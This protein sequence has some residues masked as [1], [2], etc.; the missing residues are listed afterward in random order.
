MTTGPENSP[1]LKRSDPIRVPYADLG[2]IGEPAREVMVVADADVVVAGG[3]ISGVFA[4]IA[5]GRK[6][7]RT[8]LVDRFGQVGGN[9][10]P[11][12]IIG[13][14]FD[15]RTFAGLPEDTSAIP[16]PGVRGGHTGIPKEF[17]ERYAALGGAIPP[18]NVSFYPRDSNVASYVAAEMLK[19]AGVQMLLSTFVSDPIMVDGAVAGI[20]VETK[21]GR[22][23]VKAKVTIDA[24]GEADVCRR[25]GAPILYP[26]EEYNDLDS[27]SPT[28]MGIWAVV[29]G[30][31]VPR[32]RDY[33]ANTQE[34]YQVPDRE[35]PGIGTLFNGGG[36]FPYG[37]YLRE[38]DGTAGLRTQL[39]RPHHYLDAS[40][41]LHISLMEH[42][43][44]SYIFWAT[45]QLKRNVPGYEKAFVLLVSPYLTVRGGPCIEGEYTLT[46]DDCKAGRRFDDVI[47]LYG[48]SR[49]MRHTRDTFGEPRFTDMPF[50]ALVPKQ[51]DGLL[52]SGRCASGVPDTLVRHRMAVM[53]M[54][55][56]SGTAAAL[57]AAHGVQPRKLDVRLL[58]GELLDAGFDL[59]DR[60]R[61]REL[62]L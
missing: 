55:Q 4:A 10:G 50:R 49:G 35:I 17:I 46:M 27:H 41:S 32:L 19:D 36:G 43:V 44:R 16:D 25:A 33:L 26:K 61:V 14:S 28:S 2:T 18:H 51:V 47:Y 62:G 60:T 6:G 11:G 3:G 30:I 8:V 22:Q 31:D 24:T 5:A 21:G 9:M 13:G 42:E 56:A 15:G 20:C 57:C 29:G 53:H 58:Q 38:E 7:A 23:A 40:N 54:G 12:M 45:Q 52:V 39:R 34:I 1:P 59:G 48:E 37:K